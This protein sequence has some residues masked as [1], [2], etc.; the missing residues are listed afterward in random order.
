LLA[1][2][3]VAVLPALGWGISGRLD[4]VDYPRDFGQ[5]R[6]LLA[7]DHRPGAVVVLPFDAYRRFGWNHDRTVLDPIDRWLDRTVIVSADLPVARSGDQGAPPGTLL[8]RG[9]DRLAARVAAQLHTAAGNDALAARLLGSDGVRWVVVESDAG[10]QVD[11]TLLTGLVRHYRGS[12]LSLYEVPP[13]WVR[14]AADPLR[15]YSAPVGAVIAA[16]AAAAAL[17]LGAGLMT[18]LWAGAALRARR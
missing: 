4:A 5:V 18:G 2:L 8:V 9:E 14:G 6:A 15:G 17:L 3:P 11:R 13:R 12:D 7:A 1:V 10:A 16:D